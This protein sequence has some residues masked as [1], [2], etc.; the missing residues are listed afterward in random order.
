MHEDS[1]TEPSEP[2][3]PAS[4]EQKRRKSRGF[5]G[6][7]IRLFFV[8]VFVVVLATGGVAFWA[9]ETFKKPA[10]IATPVSVMIAP[11]ASL[12][13]IA[14]ILH[15]AGL[16]EDPAIFALG[17]RV[18]GRD[19]RLTAG[20]YRFEPGVDAYAILDALED[21]RVVQR[22]FTAAEGLSSYE[23]V[24]ALKEAP[25][26][27]GGIETIPPE[28]SLLPETYQYAL[29]ETRSEVLE[30]MSASLNALRDELWERRAKGLPF[31]TWEEALIL[32]S[33][34]EKETGL[35]EERP[36]VAAVFV[37]RMR[38]GMRLQSDPT[39]I[40]GI[41]L[42]EGT[43]GRGIRRSELRAKTP[44]NTYV[45]NGLPPTPIANA[46]RDA[47]EAV[48]NPPQT[49]DLYF[50]ADGTGGHAFARTLAEHNRNVAEWRK[51]ERQ[52]KQA[53]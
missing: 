1:Q 13:R 24:A 5:L 23:I 30:R 14:D 3:K 4:P 52:R 39:V 32:A 41:T 50:V 48:L 45:I 22:F 9:Y 8:S 38:K 34:V 28:G 16:V 27:E 37:N 12:A 42:G 7:L 44:Y 10:Q 51:I 18:L 47:I 17:A 49:D 53:N 46:G 29:G 15:K 21:H 26:L 43:L 25:A 19:R 2:S 6:T 11:G 31:D 35:A 40:Y 33:I 20:E 36:R